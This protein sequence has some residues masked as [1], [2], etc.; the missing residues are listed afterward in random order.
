MTTATHGL[1]ALFALVV[2]ACAA[3]RQ[4]QIST[5]DIQLE[6]TATDT[7][8]GETTLVVAVKDKHGKPIENPGTLSVRGDMNHAG[9]APVFAEAETAIDGIFTLPFEWTMGGGWIVEASLTLANGDVASQTFHYEIL[10]EASE[11]EPADMGME[12]ARMPGESSAV[13]MRITNRGKSDIRIVAAESAAAEHINFL[14]T[15]V[16]NDIARMEA[17]DAL[18]IPAGETLELRPGD[19]HIMLTALRTDLLP[20]SQITLQLACSA[21]ETYDLEISIVDMLMTELDDALE[22]GDL[23]FSNRWARPA[24]AGAMDEMSHDDME[25]NSAEDDSSN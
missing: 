19:A 8:V 6:L 20:E 2:L 4:Q 7:L 24:R 17:L 10:T 21:G 25:M 18:L 14:R 23:V 16:E 22:L 11:D 12:H 1:T 3:C 5:T 15:I 13:Y 9:M